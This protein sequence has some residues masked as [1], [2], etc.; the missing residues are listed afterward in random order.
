M[1]LPEFMEKLQ[2]A[3]YRASQGNPEFDAS[4]M[5]VKVLVHTEYGG[6][7]TAG[8]K[9]VQ[10]A[11]DGYNDYLRLIPTSDLQFNFFRKRDEDT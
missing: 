7:H 2:A 10:W 3:I 4:Q 11:S 1:Y 5:K 9:D 8:F 6:T